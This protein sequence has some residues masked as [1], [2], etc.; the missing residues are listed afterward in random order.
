MP[1]ALII[2]GLNNPLALSLDS[3]DN[4]YVADTFNHRVLFF[5]QPLSSN[6][7]TPDRVFGQPNLSSVAPN[8][9][10]AI[11]AQG[12]HFPSGVALDTAG[13]LYIADSNNHRVLVY[14]GTR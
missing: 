7:T 2:R 11:S 8:R 5:E 3:Q 10:G 4:L 6:D 13:N 12:L 14:L 1:A 9:G